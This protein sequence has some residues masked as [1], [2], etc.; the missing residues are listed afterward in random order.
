MTTNPGRLV[1]GKTESV[2]WR[3]IWLILATYAAFAGL[4]WYADSLPWWLLVPLAGYVVCL[5]GSLSHEVVHGHPTGNKL[6]NE[7]LI[8][9]N[10]VLWVPFRRYAYLHR[11]HHNDDRLTDPY[12]D[13]ESWFRS[14]Q[15]GSHSPKVQ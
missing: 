2:E 7:A 10:L 6:L 3:T 5:H 13:P 15:S 9:P 11:V 14:P 12:D 4:T 1:R 8:F